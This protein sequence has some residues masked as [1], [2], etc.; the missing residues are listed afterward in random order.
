[1][2]NL[3]NG[4]I[5]F[6]ARKIAEILEEVPLY[7]LNEIMELAHESRQRDGDIDGIDSTSSSEEE[8]EEEE[9]TD[10]EEEEEEEEEDE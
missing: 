1:M 4:E 3:S 7:Y 6:K 9:T 8:E 5:D 2:I 10:E